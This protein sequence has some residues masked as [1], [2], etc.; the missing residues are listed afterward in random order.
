M[1]DAK[2]TPETARNEP[3][4]APYD[5]AGTDALWV[6]TDQANKGG[7]DYEARL[8]RL[9]EIGRVVFGLKAGE[10]MHMATDP[11]SD[12][13]F[14]RRSLDK[15]TYQYPSGHLLAG[16]D[17]YDWTPLP[18]H[19]GISTGRAKPDIAPAPEFKL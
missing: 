14:I 5:P 1:P 3:K 13:Y 7:G 17:H 6:S 18:N 16:T 11:I 19:D 2:I 12:G 15:P 9:A 10:L 4:P 8:K